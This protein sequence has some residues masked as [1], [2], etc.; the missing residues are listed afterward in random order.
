VL[1]AYRFSAEPEFLAA[2]RRTA[3]GLMSA[4]HDDGSL[5][6]RFRPGWLAAVDSV[7][8]TGNAQVAYCWLR[9]FEYTGEP[10]YREAACLANQYVRRTV[11]FDGPP[12][13]RGGTKGS[14][15]ID[16][17]YAPYEYLSWAAKFL[18]DSLMLEMDLATEPRTDLTTY[19]ERES[20]RLRTSDLLAL[21]SHASGSALDIGA[22]DGHFAHLLADRF[23]RVTALD[24]TLPEVADPRID[25][26]AGDV[27]KLPFADDSF[28][29]VVCAEVLEHIDPPLLRAASSELIRV[30]R[31]HLLIGVPYKQ[32][33]RVGR[34]TCI[35]CGARNPPWGHLSTFDEVRLRELFG[36]MAVVRTSFVGVDDNATNFISSSLMDLAGNPYGTYG[37]DE[38]CTACGNRLLQPPRRRFHQRILTRAAHW[39]LWLTKPFKPRHPTWIHL[40]LC[41]H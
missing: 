21:S 25:C 20:E 40:L 30:T 6:G 1:E 36:A 8:L 24:L 27:T 14:F 3:D 18:A 22:R 2:A 34:T 31:G 41:K 37:Q 7:C 4:L 12:E 23:D 13:T 17:D 19:H 33:T 35:A 15:P 16:G 29:L 26:V 32:D 11:Q 39:S 10:R 9:M 28:D 5:P 38:L